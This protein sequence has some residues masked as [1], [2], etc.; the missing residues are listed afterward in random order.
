MDSV[1]MLSK[2][3][4]LSRR[5]ILEFW[6]NFYKKKRK[7]L[8]I[9]K[10][11]NMWL[12][13]SQLILNDCLNIN[14]LALISLHSSF[15]RLKN[16]HPTI[17]SI[18]HHLMIRNLMLN[19]KINHFDMDSPKEKKNS[20]HLSSKSVCGKCEKNISSLCVIENEKNFLSG[21]NF[22][23]KMKTLLTTITFSPSQNVCKTRKVFIF[24]SLVLFLV[25]DPIR[26]YS[27]YYFF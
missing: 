6:I 12:I 9:K 15:R 7:L 8:K 11:N 5:D 4:F 2:L 22:Q 19:A 3:I 24:F 26:C 25:C 13:Y 1:I 16:T 18:H 20:R 23:L 21:Y 10:L 17:S 27:C 14:W